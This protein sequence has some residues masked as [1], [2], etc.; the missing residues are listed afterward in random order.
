MLFK[1]KIARDISNSVAFQGWRGYFGMEMNFTYPTLE[2]KFYSEK[3][4]RLFERNKFP[5]VN[6]SC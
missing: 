1:T 4:N 5:N 2:Y 6:Q 3:K